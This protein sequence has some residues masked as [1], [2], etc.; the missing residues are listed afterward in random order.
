MV[1]ESRILLQDFITDMHNYVGILRAVANGQQTMGEISAR[2]GLDGRGGGAG[3]LAGQHLGHRPRQAA[4]A[5]GRG[6][7]GRSGDGRSGFGGVG[8]LASDE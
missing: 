4:L 3:R 7:D 1:D 2:T 8:H 6:D 5:T